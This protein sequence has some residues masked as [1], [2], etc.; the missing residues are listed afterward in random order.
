VKRGGERL[1]RRLRASPLIAG[2]DRQMLSDDER[3]RLDRAIA[4]SILKRT[5]AEPDLVDTA[6]AHALLAQAADLLMASVQL[7]LNVDGRARGPI[8]SG[9]VMVRIASIPESGFLSD[10]PY[11]VLMLRLA[12]HRLIAAIGDDDAFHQS[13]ER[14]VS[15]LDRLPVPGVS[16][17][18]G[19]VLS[20][21]L[22][23]EFAFGRLPD[24]FALLQRFELIAQED[25]EITG[26]TARVAK[27]GQNARN[28]R[29]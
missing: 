18:E 4:S 21:L 23:D 7:V 17:A 13:A 27:A 26:L 19:M 16:H 5:T 2:L 25:P 1:A 28:A 6:F 14:L 15:L 22:L 29:V 8:A 20:M 12:Q 9:M 11:V 10:W 24:W 3:A